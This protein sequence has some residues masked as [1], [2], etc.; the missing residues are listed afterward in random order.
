VQTVP[1]LRRATADYVARLL[2][3]EDRAGRHDWK[4]WERPR[5]VIVPDSRSM[6]GVPPQ[7]QRKPP[8]PFMNVFRYDRASTSI[9]A[10]HPIGMPVGIVLFSLVAAIILVNLTD[11]KH[12]PKPDPPSLPNVIPPT[13]PSIPRYKP[14]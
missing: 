5:Y 14:Q 7:R 12:G 10:R 3:S 1:G 6:G 11:P 4:P 13:F 9:W 2:Q 8:E